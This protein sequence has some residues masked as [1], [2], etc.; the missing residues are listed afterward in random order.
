MGCTMRKKKIIAETYAIDILTV[1]SKEGKIHHGLLAE[2]I[3]SKNYGTI[4]KTL[5][6]LMEDGLI[7]DER[8]EMTN[9]GKYVGV[10]RYIWLTSKGKS[11]AKKLVEITKILSSK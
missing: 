8:E 6:V 10:K 11:V 9:N 5:H 7:E 4:N 1:L 3:E 2:K